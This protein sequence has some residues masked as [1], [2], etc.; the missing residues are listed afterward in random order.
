MAMDEEE[1]T[2]TLADRVSELIDARKPA[3][4]EIKQRWAAIPNDVVLGNGLPKSAWNELNSALMATVL[5]SVA[6]A[7]MATVIVSGSKDEREKATLELGKQALDV[8]E[9]FGRFLE[10]LMS[11]R[12]PRAEGGCDE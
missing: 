1:N 2:R 5:C 7:K 9:A 10:A 3:A 6:S 4:E 12:L 8:E 11:T